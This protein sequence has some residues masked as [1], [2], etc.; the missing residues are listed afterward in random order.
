MSQDSEYTEDSYNTDDFL[1]N[2]NIFIKQ[3]RYEFPLNLLNKYGFKSFDLNDL[4]QAVVSATKGE[5]D[6]LNRIENVRK[7]LRETFYHIKTNFRGG[8]DDYWELDEIKQDFQEILD[9]LKP[10]NFKK[11][12]NLA[13]PEEKMMVRSISRQAN[14]KLPEDVQREIISHIGYGGRRLKKIK[15]KRRKSINLLKKVKKTRSIKQ[16]KRTLRRK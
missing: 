4:T 5:Q 1:H 12:I 11:I 13:T 8:D 16:K 7:Y 14:T 2:W 15:S 3:Y 6:G 10:D 9:D